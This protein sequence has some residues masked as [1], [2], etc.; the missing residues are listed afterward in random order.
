MGL[1]WI[2]RHLWVAVC[3]WIIVYLLGASPSVHKT[4]CSETKCELEELKDTFSFIEGESL[5]L[6]LNL[7]GIFASTGSACSSPTLKPSSVLMAI[8]K[9]PEDAHGSIR[10]SLGRWTTDED[11]TYVIK[12]LP[13]IVKRLRK[14]S[15]SGGEIWQSELP[16]K[17]S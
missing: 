2:Q 3:R 6:E 17:T 9:N 7:A 11:I 10:F 1:C 12:V 14:F 8:G 4:Y 5:L 13:G 16:R 15:P